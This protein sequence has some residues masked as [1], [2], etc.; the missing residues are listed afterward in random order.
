VW[1]GAFREVFG[2]ERRDYAAALAAHYA[3]GPKPDWQEQHVSSYAGAHPWEDF[4]ETW[5]HYLHIVDTLETADAF[6]L[7]VRTKAGRKPRLKMEI[8]VDPYRQDDFDALVDAWLSFTY[9]GN[10]LNQCMG[11]PDFYP[12]ILATAVLRKFRFVHGLFRG[13]V[14][15]S[16]SHLV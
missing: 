8:D 9:A 11:Q 12:F 5:A 16:I 1:H 7:R 15:K 6:G 4:A 10:S 14:T 2:N 3:S 13:S